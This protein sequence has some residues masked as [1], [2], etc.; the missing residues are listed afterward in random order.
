MYEREEEAW[1]PL[2]V[3]RV[4]A[5]FDVIFTVFGGRKMATGR[6][7]APSRHR[8][9]KHKFVR[10]HHGPFIIP[11]VVYTAWIPFGMAVA[12]HPGTL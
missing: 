3:E 9:Q 6:D 7:I 8:S 2:N 5:F 4:A 10:A 11:S 12:D 1:R